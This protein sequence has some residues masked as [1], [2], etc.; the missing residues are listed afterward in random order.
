[1]SGAETQIHAAVYCHKGQYR[2]NNEDNFY[3][4]GIW[5]PADRLNRDVLETRDASQPA[6]FAVCDGMGGEQDGEVAALLAVTWLHRAREVFLSGA[7]PEQQGARHISLLSHALF[8][9]C[10]ERGKRM[11]STLAAAVLR[12]GRLY[13]FGLGDSR[14]YLL[15]GRTLRRL[16]EDHTVAAEMEQFGVSGPGGAAASDSHSHQL[17]QYFGMDDSEYDASPCHSSLPLEQGMR[18]LLCSDGLSGVVDEMTIAEL[19]GRGAPEQTAKALVNCAL[20]AG[21]RDNITAMVLAV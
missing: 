11:G 5:K 16:T 4:N 19:L 1:M 18:L 15:S 6:L 14:I 21:G 8:H 2:Q 9:A 13:V 12:G 10:L 7:E 20:E 17:T 3:L